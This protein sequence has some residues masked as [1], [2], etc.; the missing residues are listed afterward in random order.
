M[1][2]DM[3][4]CR[5]SNVQD[6]VARLR[7]DPDAKLLAG[8]QS[9]LAAIR[10]RLASPTLLID[11]Q[12]IPEMR[13][14]REDAEGIWIGA[15]CTHAQVADAPLIK[16]KVPVLAGLAAGI[17]D[18][19]VRNRG[20]IGGSIANA[21]PAAC[22][23]A[24]LLALGATIHTDRRT[25]TA[26]DFFQGLFS[27]ALEPDELVTGVRV[28]AAS[29]ACYLKFEQPASR[30]AMAGVAVFR[31]TQ[32]VRVAITGLG[33]GVMRW[34]EAEKVLSRHFSAQSLA[35]LQLEPDHA[36]GD[37]HASAEYKRHIGALL[38][39]RAVDVM[40]GKAWHGHC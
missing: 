7:Q 23:P 5:A 30:F 2:A 38:T 33:N 18:Q 39:R 31:Q 4:Y 40:N 19:Q 12:A 24:G 32:P 29:Q 36:F 34:T 8:G 20:T 11:L 3:D 17:A 21:D 1:S 13:T 37:L 26:D 35:G 27:T 22:W 6:A 16:N 10:L 14:V 28:P 15:M 9:L 25:L